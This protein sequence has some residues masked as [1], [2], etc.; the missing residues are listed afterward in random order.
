MQGMGLRYK[1]HGPEGPT[2]MPPKVTGFVQQQI[3]FVA[4]NVYT[5]LCRPRRLG[6]KSELFNSPSL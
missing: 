2:N 4:L 5:P 1:S 6:E 3:C